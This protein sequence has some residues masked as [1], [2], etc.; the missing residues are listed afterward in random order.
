MEPGHRDPRWPGGAGRTLPDRRERAGC[1]GGADVRGDVRVRYDRLV[2][3]VAILSGG[4]YSASGSHTLVEAVPSG[5]WY[6]ASQPGGRTLRRVHD[7]C[8]SAERRAGAGRAGCSSCPRRCTPPA[9]PA[10]ACR[11]RRRGSSRP[12]PRGS[13]TFAGKGGWPSA[14]PLRPTTPSLRTASRPPWARGST[15]PRR[16]LR[17]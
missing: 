5:W 15:P 10:A 8:R 7:G 4:E 2:G 11:P 3:V 13:R 6:T 16:W 14:T 17:C 12:R 1:P 9:G